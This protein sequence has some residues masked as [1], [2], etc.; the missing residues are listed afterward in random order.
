MA[1]IRTIKPEF[2]TSESVCECSPLAR[3]LFIG[4]WC[5]ADREGLLQ[6]KPKTLKIRYLPVDNCDIDNL[7]SEL[8]NNGMIIIHEDEEGLICEIPGFSMHQVINNREKESELSSRVSHASVRVK[9]EGRKEGKERKGKDICTEQHTAHVPSVICLLLNTKKQYPIIQ[10]DID[11]WAYLYP[12]VDVL[13]ELKNMSGWLDSNP[14]KRKTENGIMKFVNGWLKRVQDKG[15]TPGYIANSQSASAEKSSDWR[16]TWP[17][18]V[19]RGKELGITQLPD[20]PPPAFKARV[21]KADAG[22]NHE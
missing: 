17:T 4:L 14:Q 3:L 9:A 18:I 22:E 5:E 8:E 13:Q 1:R 19:A 16:S 21:I 6:W 15:G 11:K 7:A 20:E 2:F 12:A 10:S